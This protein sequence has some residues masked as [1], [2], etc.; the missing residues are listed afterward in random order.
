[1]RKFLLLENPDMVTL[2]PD[3]AHPQ[4]KVLANGRTLKRMKTWQNLP[5]TPQRFTVEGLV[6]GGS[7]WALGVAL[8][9]I[10]R[11]SYICFSPENGVW[12]L[13]HDEG[14]FVALT[15]PRTPL[16]LTALPRRVWVCLDYEQGVVTFF[17]SDTGQEI[18]TLPP[19]SFQDQKLWPWFWLLTPGTEL[20]LMG[21]TPQALNRPL[22]SSIA[23]GR[24]QP[25][26]GPHRND[27][28]ADDDPPPA[29]GDS[30]PTAGT[31]G[32]ERGGRDAPQ[33]PTTGSPGDPQ[34]QP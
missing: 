31:F 12:G 9:K 34:P 8:E 22:V 14:L 10:D 19:A 13:R 32:L 25:S 2:D 27:T 21:G 3:T 11:R 7:E 1:W 16:A 20:T 4:L 26:P 28:G 5:E 15:I 33:P 6:G 29:P 23:L 30:S 17:N 24:P 18:F